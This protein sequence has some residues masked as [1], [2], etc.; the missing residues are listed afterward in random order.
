MVKKTALYDEHVALSAHMVEFA[1]TLLPVRYQ[2]EKDEH[3]AVRNAVGMFDISHMGEF[4][5]SGA[6]AIKF[7]QRLLTNNVDALDI[8]KAQ[9][10]LLLN[11]DGGMVDDLMLY[12]LEENRFLLCVNAANIEKDKAHIIAM[13]HNDDIVFD[14]V[15]DEYSLIALQG[16]QA[17]RLLQRTT[18][19]NLPGRHCVNR[20]TIAGVDVDVARTGYTGEDG[21]EIFV[22]NMH[23]VKIWQTLLNAGQNFSLLPCGLAARDSLRLEAGLRLYG[24]DMDE[25]TSP[26]EAG[27]SFAID[28]TKPDF[29][30]K[31]QLLERKER[32]AKKLIGFR[33]EEKGVARHGFKIFDADHREI[34]VVT[35]GS[36]PPTQDFAIG[37]AYVREPFA[38]QTIFVDIRGRL[39]KALV[40]RPRFL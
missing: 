36:W 22:Q 28:M 29:L 1:N 39:V 7:L 33:L 4:I 10:T 15:S 38:H 40:R 19:S 34:G 18:D 11:V 2:S 17:E 23:A 24:Q 6:D 3:L 14:N 35:S 30:G 9:Y 26:L 25:T 27:L 16:P 13:R 21:F 20:L 12:R 37:F 31:A 32:S 8:Q 5:I